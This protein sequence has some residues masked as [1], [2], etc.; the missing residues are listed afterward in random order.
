MPASSRIV[1]WRKDDPFG[2]EFAEVTLGADYLSAT[3]VALGTEPAPYRLDYTLETGNGWVTARLQV[4]TR[5]GGWRR[6][7][8]L[9]RDAGGDWTIETESAGEAPLPPPGGASEPLRRALDCD[10]GLS[11]LTNSMPVLREGLLARGGPKEF[12]MAWVSVPDLGVHADRQRYTFQ[13][14]TKDGRRVV[15]F[16]SVDDGF[17]ADLLFDPDGLVVDYPGLAQRLT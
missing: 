2:V 6:Q 11:P 13:R 1:A 9:R 7:L 16:E 8:D 12:V 15:R 4:S 3:G 5:G 14:E 10:L 17:V